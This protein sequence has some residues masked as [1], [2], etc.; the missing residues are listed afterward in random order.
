M[1]LGRWGYRD[2]ARELLLGGRLLALPGLAWR[3]RQ[4]RRG[5][6]FAAYVRGLLDGVLDRPLPL[7]RLGLR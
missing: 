4:S 7:E 1:R 6:Q 3:A 2:A 5:Q